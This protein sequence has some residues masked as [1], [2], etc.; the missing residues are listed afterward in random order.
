MNDWDTQKERTKSIIGLAIGLIFG[1]ILGLP[2][3]IMEAFVTAWIGMGL[4]GNF[5]MFFSKLKDRLFNGYIVGKAR[6]ES[7]KENLIGTLIYAALGAFFWFIVYTVTGPI[8]PI[9]RI[10]LDMPNGVIADEN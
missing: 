2:G 10:L 8:I 4:C 5:L 6:G 9:A 3:G 7:L 1:F